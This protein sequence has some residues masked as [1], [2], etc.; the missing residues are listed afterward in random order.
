MV[1]SNFT[2]FI[3]PVAFFRYSNGFAFPLLII[4]YHHFLTADV[5]FIA[6][7]ELLLVFCQQG[8]GSRGIARQCYS[9]TTQLLILYYILSYEENLLASTK[10]LGMFETK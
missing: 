10:Q 2:S 7:F 5:D 6:V 1:N 3:I 4:Y 8:E 9:I